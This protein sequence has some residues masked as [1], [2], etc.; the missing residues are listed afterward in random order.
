MCVFEY[1][2][3]ACEQACVHVAAQCR[4][5]QAWDWAANHKH[6]A[7]DPYSIFF[8]PPLSPLSPHICVSL[9][10]SALS[11]LSLPCITCLSPLFSLSISFSLHT[12]SIFYSYILNPTLHFLS[13]SPFFLPRPHYLFFLLSHILTLI[14]TFPSFPKSFKVALY[15][16]LFK[17]RTSQLQYCAVTCCTI[18][19]IPLSLFMHCFS[20]SVILQSCLMSL[21]VA[22]IHR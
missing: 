8:S 10:F 17:R 3:L 16:S 18:S 2:P 12:L 9:L 21:A 20:L 19:H 14:H 13:L 4:H 7:T 5:D 22:V 15:P 6:V 1:P 11:R